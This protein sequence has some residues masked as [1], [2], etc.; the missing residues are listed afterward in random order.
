MR[1]KIGGTLSEDYINNLAFGALEP[2]ISFQN[3]KGMYLSGQGEKNIEV[4]ITNV[5][6]VKLVISKIYENNLLAAQKNGY[7]PQEKE[8]VNNYYEDNAS[9][10]A[11]D[12]IY[13]QEVETR[14]LPKYGSSRLLHLDIEDK[15]PEIQRDLS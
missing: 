8:S 10:T 3:S 15:L 5:E 1:G 9:S 14:L 4:R 13:E 6:K 7:Y 12:V 2:A 11:G